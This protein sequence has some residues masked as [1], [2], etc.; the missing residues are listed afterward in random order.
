MYSLPMPELC[1]HQLDLPVVVMMARRHS[2]ETHRFIR[3]AL[4]RASLSHTVACESSA[5]GS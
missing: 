4:P 2:V 3:M 5:L 1:H